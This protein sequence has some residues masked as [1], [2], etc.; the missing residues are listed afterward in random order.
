MKDEEFRMKN[1]GWRLQIAGTGSEKSLSFLKQLCK[2]SGVENS[3]DFL[4]FQTDMEKIYK[5]SEIFVLS[6]RYEG[7]GLVLIEAMSQ[8]CACVACD[9][10]GRQR[11]II[12][13]DSFGICCETENVEALANSIYKMMADDEYRKMVQKNA[14]ERSKFYSLDNTI[15]RWELFLKETVKV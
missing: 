1:P 14:I 2:D 13:D 8:G 3:V 11:E 7:F 4:G 15:E 10:K 5:H 12:T 6:S 9:F